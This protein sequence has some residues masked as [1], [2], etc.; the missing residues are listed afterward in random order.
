MGTHISLLL[1]Q[2]YLLIC[3]FPLPQILQLIRQKLFID[4]PFS[5]TEPKQCKPLTFYCLPVA[6]L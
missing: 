6:S 3:C 4:V 1:I 2:R 5:L